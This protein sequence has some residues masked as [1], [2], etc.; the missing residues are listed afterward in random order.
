MIIIWTDFAVSTLTDIFIYYK[1]VA[2]EKVAKKIK[3]NIF[4]ATK[5]LLKHPYSGQIEPILEVLKKEH[6]YLIISNF[7]IIYLLVDE[8]ILITDV[9]DTR[10][11]PSKINNPNRKSDC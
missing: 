10:Q 4:K 5:Q 11:E 3:S 8:G 1:E 6:R 2:G 9:F 7:K